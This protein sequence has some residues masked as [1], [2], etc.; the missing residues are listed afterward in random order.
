MADGIG[1][2]Q[3]RNRGTIGGSI[4]NNDPTADYPSACLALNA[5]IH[6]SNRKIDANK[7]FKGMFETALKKGELIETVEF[8]VPTKS[9]YEKF[10][11]P[12]SL[13]AMVGV[14]V[15]KYKIEVTVAVTG[16]QSVVYRCKEIENALNS[17]FSA[18]AIDGVKIK[19]SGL[20]S[21]IHA[22]SDYRAHLIKVLAKKAVAGCK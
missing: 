21:D 14:Y 19:S 12:A 1:D 22:S 20:N 17:N 5:T 3:V 8:Q 9:C 15:A 11:S 16:A 10:P 4:A 18:S 2:A 7:F 6:T 13:Y